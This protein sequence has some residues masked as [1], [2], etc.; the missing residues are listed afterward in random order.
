[1]SVLILLYVSSC[2]YL[3]VFSNTCVL[4]PLLHDQ[5]IESHL[6]S[7]GSRVNASSKR[8]VAGGAAGVSARSVDAVRSLLQSLRK[9][10]GESRCTQYYTSLRQRGIETHA[11]LLALNWAQ[12]ARSGGAL[13]SMLGSFAKDSLPPLVSM[14][15]RSPR[16]AKAAPCLHLGR[17]AAARNGWGVRQGAKIGG[18]AAPFLRQALG[19][20]PREAHAADM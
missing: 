12:E 4:L 1:M 2:S 13:H 14:P 11:D 10:L 8:T 6:L 7:C 9:D 17:T 16:Q 18:C 20:S 19:L 3:R 5:E 15:Q